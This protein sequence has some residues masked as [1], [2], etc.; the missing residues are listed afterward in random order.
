M[1]EPKLHSHTHRHTHIDIRTHT[2]NYCQLDEACR[3]KGE[4]AGA[5]RLEGVKGG[6]VSKGDERVMGGFKG[7]RFVTERKRLLRKIMRNDKCLS[8]TRLQFVAVSPAAAPHAHF[9]IQALRYVCNNISCFGQS[10][11]EFITIHIDGRKLEL[12]FY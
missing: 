11:Y 7:F 6:W 5:F 2:P 4:A 1:S 10:Q 8:V 9:I 12:D 3:E